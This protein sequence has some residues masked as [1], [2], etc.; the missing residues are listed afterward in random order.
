MVRPEI[1]ELIQLGAFPASKDA[2]TEVIEHQEQLLRKIATPVSND[3]ARQLITLFGPDDYFGGAWTLLHIVETAPH[4]PL[5]DCL[6]DDSNEWILL[7]KKRC[8]NWVEQQ[9]SSAEPEVGDG[10]AA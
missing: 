6:T 2:V 3:E 7:L 5:M 9:Q 8:E 4:W 10:P 1:T